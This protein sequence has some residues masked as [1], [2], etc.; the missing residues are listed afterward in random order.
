M[1]GR[2]GRGRVCGF[3]AAARG[4]GGRAGR[5]RRGRGSGKQKAEAKGGFA[6]SL[7]TRRGAER[8]GRDGG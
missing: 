8:I 2:A 1:W 7:L 4:A 6:A 5:S 3:R